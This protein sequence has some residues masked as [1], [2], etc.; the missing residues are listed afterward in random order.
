MSRANCLSVLRILRLVFFLICTTGILA[1]ETSSS[2]QSAGSTEEVVYK[3]T[4]YCLNIRYCPDF[5]FWGNSP[6]GYIT[7]TQG[8]KPV[9][10]LWVDFTGLLTFESSPLN[11]PP[12][13]GL[14]LL[15]TLVANGTLQEV[16]QFF[17]QGGDRPLFVLYEGF[18][19]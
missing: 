4:V 13:K 8:G 1:A 18:R 2:N 15:G 6:P 10:Y 19:P 7:L 3:G 16:D 5:A 12:P 11:V 14:P 17:P 9:V